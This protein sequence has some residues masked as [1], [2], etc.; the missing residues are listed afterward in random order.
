MSACSFF[1][2][3]DYNGDKDKLIDTVRKLIVCRNVDEFYVGNQGSFDFAVL[4]ALRQLQKEFFHIRYSVVLAYHPSVNRYSDAVRS[5]E[6]LFP[7]EMDKIPL[8]FAIAKR[9]EWMIS[10][11]DYAVVFVKH[12]IGGA[13]KYKE[14]A[15]K[16]GLEVINLYE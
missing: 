16:K 4:Q 3:R 12:P 7:E 10:K 13:A 5:E 6:T 8:R 15:E 14:L 9:N 2:H 1:G 11:S